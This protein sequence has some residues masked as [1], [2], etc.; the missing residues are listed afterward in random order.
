MN[1]YRLHIRDNDF[2]I[3]I[4]VGLSHHE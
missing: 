3:I 2:A 4:L 1:E